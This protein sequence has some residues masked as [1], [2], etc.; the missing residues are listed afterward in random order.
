[1]VR[2]TIEL[3]A[4]MPTARRIVAALRSM[5]MAARL[6]PGCLGCDVWTD[7][8][9]DCAVRYEVRWSSEDTM[10]RRVRCED[11]TRLLEVLESAPERPTVQFDFVT[12]CEG[13]EYVEAVRS[14]CW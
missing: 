13:L 8:A 14:G 12:R 11:F 9:D 1:M 2:L 6:E 3:Y 4:P 7:E 5:V 10:R